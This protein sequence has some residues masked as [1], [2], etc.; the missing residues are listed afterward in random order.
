[1]PTVM[2]FDGFSVVVYPADHIPDHVHVFGGGNE[3]VFNLNCP[4]GPV[5]LRETYGLSRSAI[6]SIRKV[7]N[8]RI[9]RLCHEW[10]RIHG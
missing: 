7:L 1:M 3:A 9:T 8:E 5:E 6:A 4:R 10:R 2:R